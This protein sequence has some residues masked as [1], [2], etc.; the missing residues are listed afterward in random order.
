MEAVTSSTPGALDCSAGSPLLLFVA[1][2]VANITTK[3]E[4]E[5]T[6]RQQED[7]RP[8]PEYDYVVVG[9][10]SSGCVLAS[11]LSEDKSVSVLLLERGGHEP[12]EAR[13]PG[14]TVFNINSALSEPIVAQPEPQN[15]NNTGCTLNVP[16]VLGGGS[17]INGM[18]YVRGSSEDYN[19]W[20]RITGDAGWAYRNVLRYFKKSEQNLNAPI[21]ENSRYHGRNGPQKVSWQPYRHPVLPVLAQ[22]FEATGVPARLDINAES[23]LGHSVVQTTSAGG[24]RWSAYRSYLEPVL[25]RGNL[26]VETF[27]TASRVV[28]DD[29]AWGGLRAVG[30]EYEDP[31]GKVH[32]VRARKEVVL[33]AGALHTPQLLMLSG[34]G[35]SSQ[36][37]AAGIPV[38]KELPVG[39]KLLDHPVVSSVPYKCG[40]PLCSV[41]WESRLDDLR[42]YNDNRTGPLSA[43][44]NLHQNVFARSSLAKPGTGQQP[45]FQI[46][47]Q[48]R[49]V[50]EAGVCLARDSWRSNRLVP[51]VSL[52]RPLS[53]GWLRLN[54]SNPRGQPLVKLS[55]FSD[56]AGHDLAVTVQGLRMAVRLRHALAPLGL[57]LDTEGLDA[58]LALGD[59]ES[60]AFLRCVARVNTST[61]WH[62]SG[63]CPMGRA[64]DATAVLDSRLRVRG[65]RRL[66]VA[67]ASAMPFIP[68]GNTNNPTIMLAERAADLIKRDAAI[69][70][71]IPCRGGHFRSLGP[72]A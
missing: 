71:G 41:D 58:C 50:T 14:Y 60:D 48:G 26:R 30:V 36:L 61:L 32:V 55:Y 44:N 1:G 52:I 46:M 31:Q 57:T 2:L 66:R 19:E 54:A 42:Q 8:L 43:F 27:A 62:W 22:A 10:G 35:P 29:K 45:D 25:H 11:R 70:R 37:K 69:C 24:E 9:G 6:R 12:E 28:L 53:E 63:T 51:I 16:N 39:E 47:F 20:A 13:V 5:R 59:V 23:Q 3:K 49:T 18:L 17:T 33:T 64:R 68:S 65:V 4:A 34:I 7:S 40:P 67:D 21:N 38:V 15:C 56:A 72:C